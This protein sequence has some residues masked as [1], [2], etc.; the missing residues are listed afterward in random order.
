MTFEGVVMNIP[1][2]TIERMEALDEEQASVI[3]KLVGFYSLSNSDIFDNIC[4]EELKQPVS[5]EVI[6]NTIS[7]VRTKLYER[8]DCD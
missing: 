2:R 4:N 3:V 7:D 1:A 5:N 6:E 8:I